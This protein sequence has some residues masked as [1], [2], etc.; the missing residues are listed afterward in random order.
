VRDNLLGDSLFL[1]VVAN[2]EAVELTQY[3]GLGL[4]AVADGPFV[5]D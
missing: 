4:I 5:D 1:A 3:G 2:A